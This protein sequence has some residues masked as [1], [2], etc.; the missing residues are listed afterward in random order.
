MTTK[1]TTSH[2]VRLL[3]KAEEGML[4]NKKVGLAKSKEGQEEMGSANMEVLTPVK[5][6]EGQEEIDSANMEALALV[7]SKD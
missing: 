4:R 2:L 6:E 7:K 3:E 5:S 1:T